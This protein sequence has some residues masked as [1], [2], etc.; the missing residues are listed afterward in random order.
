[1]WTW[2]ALGYIGSALFP[3]SATAGR[4]QEQKRSAEAELLRQSMRSQMETCETKLS[5]AKVTQDALIHAARQ[6]QRE[7]DRPKALV[8]MRQVREQRKMVTFVEGVLQQTQ[9]QA[10]A[11]DRSEMAKDVAA[12]QQQVAKVLE[13]TTWAKQMDGA[14]DAM[15]TIQ[16]VSQDVDEFC[17]IIGAASAEQDDELLAELEAMDEAGALTLDEETAFA[18]LEATAAEPAPAEAA[19]EA[20]DVEAERGE[21]VALLAV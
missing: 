16:E 4:K 15:A 11:M 21:R 17:A 18:E 1:V 9:S 19:A 14:D 7:G 12:G 6:A 2:A 10:A 20:E 3:G 5:A 8:I 13:Q